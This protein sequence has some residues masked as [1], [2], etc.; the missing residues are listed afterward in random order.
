M[1]TRDDHNKKPNIL[2]IMVDQMA[3]QVLPC[4]GGAVVKA[5]HLSALAEGGCGL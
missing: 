1:N 2:F 3:A 5:P 4:Y